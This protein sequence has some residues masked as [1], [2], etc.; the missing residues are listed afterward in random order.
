M[1]GK[2]SL[3]HRRSERF[4][5]LVHAKQLSYFIANAKEEEKIFMANPVFNQLGIGFDHIIQF[6]K[7]RFLTYARKR[8]EDDILDYGGMEYEKME[9]P[10]VNSVHDTIRYLLLPE[11]LTEYI[12]DL[13]SK[14]YRDAT[15]LIYNRL[16]TTHHIHLL[17]E[18]IMNN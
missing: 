10:L 17:V 14:N 15:R 7:N 9:I 3:L 5:A 12:M 18:V 16:P 2:D 8:N 11:L 13:H 6:V 4:Q 1:I